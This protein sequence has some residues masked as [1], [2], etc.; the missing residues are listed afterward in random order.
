MA[1]APGGRSLASC[2]ADK[3]V[4]IWQSDGSG[5]CW[6]CT[7]VLEDHHARTVRAVS[8][9]PEGAAL[10]TA[11]FDATASVFAREAGE[12][13]CAAT[14]EG[15][16]SEVKGVAWS[17]SGAL[18]AT[19]G[20]DKSVWV[21]AVAEG[22]AAGGF[23][24]D[25]ADPYECVGVLQGHTQDVKAVRW[26]PSGDGLLLSASYDDTLRLWAEEA[27]EEWACVQV[28]EGHTSTVWDAS[29]AGAGERMASASADGTVGL[30]LRAEGAGA[31]AGAGQGQAGFRPWRRE[32][33]LEG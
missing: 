22:A 10:A 19:C 11:S 32:D 28:L 2:S 6:R 8:W 30:W 4:R 31:G 27:P 5:G 33:A 23:G 13:A 29:F 9:S 15:H 17:P 14:L 20:R 12:W 24:G 21:W 16:E 25:D 3:T 18:L 1:W 26:H 7:A